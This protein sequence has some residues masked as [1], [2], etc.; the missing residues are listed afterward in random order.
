MNPLSIASLVLLVV[1]LVMEFWFHK[2]NR[3]E[4]QKIQ[5]DIFD[6]LAKIKDFVASATHSGMVREFHKAFGHPISDVP[7]CLPTARSDLR[8]ELIREELKEYDEAVAEGDVVKIADALSDLLYV[9]HGAALEH[10]IPINECFWE[11]HKSNMSKLGDDGLPIYREDGK[12]LKGPNYQ[13]PNLKDILE[14][15]CGGS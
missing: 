9:T 2:K 11:V 13:P 1:I 14:K 5:D 8:S 7:T 6:S 12:I 3:A 15:S 4:K 10:G